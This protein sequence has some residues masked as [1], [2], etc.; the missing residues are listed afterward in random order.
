MKRLMLGILFSLFLCSISSALAFGTFVSNTTYSSSLPDLGLYSYPSVYN[1]DDKTV[2]VSDY[3]CYLDNE[4]R[5]FQLT[6]T[7]WIE[8]TSLV[9]GLGTPQSGIG[10]WKNLEIYDI[11]GVPVAFGNEYSGGNRVGNDLISYS[12][13]G[14]GFQRNTTYENGLNILSAR[15]SEAD[16]VE[17]KMEIFKTTDGKIRAY[18]TYGDISWGQQHPMFVMKEWNG[19]VWSNIGNYYSDN[20]GGK[21]YNTE[22]NY[23]GLSYITY[24]SYVRF[25]NKDWLILTGYQNSGFSAHYWNGTNWV[26]DISPF[27][28][29]NRNSY[30]NFEV[31]LGTP[32]NS[33]WLLGGQEN[34][35]F[36]SYLYNCTSNWTILSNTTSCFNTTNLINNVTYTD[37]NGCQ[38]NYSEISYPILS[39]SILSNITTCVNS[40]TVLQNV[41]YK[42]DENCSYFYSDLT[43]DNCPEFYSCSG[44]SCLYTGYCGDTIC[45][46]GNGET[47][48][49]CCLDCGCPMFQRCKENVC[50]EKTLERTITDVGEGL[51]NFLDKLT[52]PLSNFVM[53]LGLIGVVL[54]I[55]Y[56]ILLSLEKSIRS[57]NIT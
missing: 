17:R 25:G 42:D 41:T 15:N 34:G 30:S 6:G 18:F 28:N 21:G 20:D 8:N 13:N 10:N 44:G 51:A 1:I 9:V 50:V 39:Y 45:Q 36:T 23:T 48:D 49:N 3:C 38:E 12:W 27:N 35:A 53:F 29:L 26:W 43:Y 37:L 52:N 32:N 5:G 54:F 56:S 47:Q 14:T 4:K 2:L 40:T 31:I 33:I 55:I 22:L 19:T 24:P 46:V 57:S 7:T 16:A 11:D